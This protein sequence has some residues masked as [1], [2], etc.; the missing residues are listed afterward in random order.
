MGIEKNGKKKT[1][2]RNTSANG[3]QRL[4]PQWGAG[5]M[6]VRQNVSEEECD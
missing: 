5:V 2:S 6:Q 3:V 4:R 1:L